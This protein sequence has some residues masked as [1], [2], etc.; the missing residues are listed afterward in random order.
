MGGRPRLGCVR[1]GEF[2]GIEAWCVGWCVGCGGRWGAEGC[3]GGEG[4]VSI[5]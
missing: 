3:G 1:R 5:F 4:G 2:R